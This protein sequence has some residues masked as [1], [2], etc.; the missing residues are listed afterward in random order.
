M[1]A[2][3]G[4]AVTCLTGVKDTTIGS[5]CEQSSIDILNKCLCQCSLIDLVLTLTFDL[6]NLHQ[7]YTGLYI[8]IYGNSLEIRMRL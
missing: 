3:S 8:T 2:R 1:S 6:E 5:N 4:L 7:Q